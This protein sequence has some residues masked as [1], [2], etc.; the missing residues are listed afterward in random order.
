MTRN[1]WASEVT[2]NFLRGLTLQTV[3]DYVNAF[4]RSYK[5]DWERW[6]RSWSGEVSPEAAECFRAVL[7]RWNPC[8]KL[9]GV[10]VDLRDLLREAMPHVRTL[11]EVSIHEFVEPAQN[12]R[13]AI[14]GL[15]RVLAICKNRTSE[16]GIS[17]AIMVIDIGQTGTCILPECPGCL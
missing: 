8:R 7:C 11:G 5:R 13:A 16:V 1:S 17:K 14:S 4:D 3:A 15:W 6:Q 10:R 2:L 9:G 12:L